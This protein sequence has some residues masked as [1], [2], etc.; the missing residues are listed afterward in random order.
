MTVVC[1]EIA[2]VVSMERKWVVHWDMHKAVLWDASW[3]VKL[4]DGMAG[5]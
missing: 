3:A 2:G 4:A 1:L 5:Q